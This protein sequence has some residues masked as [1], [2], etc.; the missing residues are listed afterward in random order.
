MTPLLFALRAEMLKIKRT[1]ALWLVV[2]GP[3]AVVIFATLL[4][5]QAR[6][7]VDSETN[8]WLMIGNNSFGMWAVLAMPLFIAL[9]TA[10]LGQLE[11]GNGGWKRIFAQPNPRW[12]TYFAKQVVTLGVIGLSQIALIAEILL[13]VLLM[14]ALNVHPIVNYDVPIPWGA[15]AKAGL[16]SYVAAWLMIAI[17]TWVGLRWHNFAVA[18]AVGVIAAVAGFMA[19]NSELGWYFPWS[20]AALSSTAALRPEVDA[21]LLPLALMLSIAGTLIVSLLGNWDVTRQDVL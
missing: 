15:L 14:R 20:M 9:E 11:H 3:L 16:F 6:Q 1:L 4:F 19:V 17:H 8:P 18:I 2:I 10:L 7:F 5:V 13:A 12:A 21:Q